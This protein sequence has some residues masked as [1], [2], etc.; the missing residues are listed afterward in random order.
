MNISKNNVQQ[1]HQKN[2]YRGK[3]WGWDSTSCVS[4]TAALNEEVVFGVWRGVSIAGTTHIALWMKSAWKQGLTKANYTERVTNVCRSDK[5]SDSQIGRHGSDKW[6]P[7]KTIWE[8]TTSGESPWRKWVAEIFA[9]PWKLL[10]EIYDGLMF[11]YLCCCTLPTVEACLWVVRAQTSPGGSTVSY[12]HIVC[13]STVES[14]ECLMF[15][16]LA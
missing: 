10:M 3:M 7:G 2:N 16:D 6:C 13:G 11:T 12:P 14:K 1:S 4:Q 5:V 15:L 9:R 8:W